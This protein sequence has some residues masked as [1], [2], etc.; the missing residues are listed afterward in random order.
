[1][2]DELKAIQRRVGTTFVHVTHDQEEAMAIADRI[3]VMNAG[4]IEDEGRPER[5][6]LRPRS[7]FAAAFMGE[8][9]LIPAR[10]GGAENGHLLLDTALGPVRLALRGDLSAVAPGTRLALGVRPEHLRPDAEGLRIPAI[11]TEAAFFGTHHRIHARPR[12][13]GPELVAHLPQAARVAPG[14]EVVLSFAPASAILLP[15]D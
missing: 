9:N 1:M 4:R 12:P 10:V 5:V 11:V 14:D 13:A 2:Q 3:V 8:I 6:Y 15:E 7:R